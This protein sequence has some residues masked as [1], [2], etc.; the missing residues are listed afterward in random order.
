MVLRENGGRIS[1]RQRSVKGVY[2]KTLPMGGGENIAEP[3]GGNQ[4][5][6]FV[7]QTKSYKPPPLEGINNDRF[8]IITRVSI[9]LSIANS[10]EKLISNLT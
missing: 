6:F 8:L 4:I 1:R 10:L 9:I 3:L 5:N 7:T 2:E